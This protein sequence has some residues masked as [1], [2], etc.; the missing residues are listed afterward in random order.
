MNIRINQ[1]NRI[2]Q[3]YSLLL[4]DFHF[5]TREKYFFFL[6][7][8]K[9]FKF[10]EFFD[11]VK[12][13]SREVLY[14]SKYSFSFQR[15]RILD[16]KPVFCVTHN[17]RI[18]CSSRTLHTNVSRTFLKD[19]FHLIHT[20]D[21]DKNCSRKKIHQVLTLQNLWTKVWHK[22]KSKLLTKCNQNNVLTT[23]LWLHSVDCLSLFISL[24]IMY[25]DACYHWPVFL[26]HDMY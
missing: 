11:L 20:F 18:G 21:F 6:K 9:S 7:I 8:S 2:Q 26:W 3:I 19:D 12:R 25:C 5:Y 13:S 4:N 15:Q 17:T 14:L 16:T 10:R 24:D 22:L 1:I 23:T